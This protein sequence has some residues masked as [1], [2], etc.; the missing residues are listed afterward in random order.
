MQQ[1]EVDG[2]QE[3]GPDSLDRLGA[4][5]RALGNRSGPGVIHAPDPWGGGTRGVDP[6]Q[7]RGMMITWL[8]LHSSSWTSKRASSNAMRSIASHCLPR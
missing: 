6:G 5:D 1:Q 3:G 8:P 7:G 4:P 2:G